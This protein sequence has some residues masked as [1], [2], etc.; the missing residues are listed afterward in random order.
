M[1]VV[2]TSRSEKKAL[3]TVRRILDSFADRIGNDTWKTVITAEGLSA[4]R[5]LLRKSATKN[6]AVACHWIRSRSRSDLVW[7]VGNRECFNDNG[8]VPVHSTKINILHRE[9]ENGWTYLPLLK[10]MVAVA[11]LF[12][13]YGKASDHFQQ[14]LKS[15]SLER[16]PFRHEWMSCK[17]L[18]AIVKQAGSGAHESNDCKWLQILQNGEMDIC[19][20]AR[21]VA[22]EQ[23]GKINF[24]KLPPLAQS[25]CWLILCHHKLPDLADKE[26]C[27]SFK[28]VS[29]KEFN[30]MLNSI[31]A[32]WGYENNQALNKDGCF[33]FSEGLVGPKQ[34]QW[35]KAVKKW[36]HRLLENREAFLCLFN[37][38]TDKNAFR[39]LLNY[40]R[41][42]LVLGDHYVSSMDAEN[43]GRWCNS[44]KLWAN[45][46]ISGMRQLL[47]E[48]LVRVC[49]QAVK[50]AHQLPRLT[51]QMESVTDNKT[52]KKKSSEKFKWQDTVVEEIKAFRKD[53]EERYAYFTINMASTGCGKTFANAKIMQALSKDGRSLR[54]ILALGLRSLTLQTGDE[55]RERIRLDDTE[56]AVLI[57]STAVRELHRQ[58]N[59][60]KEYEPAIDGNLEEL[61]EE[62][63][64]YVDT[65]D[66]EQ[67]KFLD[68][69]FKAVA[70]GKRGISSKQAAKNHALLYKPVLVATIDHMMGATE[71]VRGG[72]FLLPSLRLMSSD[73][74]IDEIDDFGKKDLIAISRLVHLAG[75]YGRNVT[76][77]SATIPPDLAEGLY[78]AYT[79]GLACHNRFFS[80]KKRPALIHCD[81]FK[82]QVEDINIKDRRFA[83]VHEYFVK[84]RVKKL[85]QQPIQRKAYI[86]NCTA[87]VIDEAE[88]CIEHNTVEIRYFEQ[89]KEAAETLHRQN[90]VCDKRTGKK[91]SFGVVRTANIKPCV[92]LCRYLL[93]CSWSKD[94]TVRV[95]AYH[96]RQILLLR[97]EQEKYLDKLLKRHQEKSN[98]ADFED[99]VV[100]K[101]IDSCDS[102]NILF[103]LVDTPVEEVGRDHDWDW[104]VVEPSSYRSIIQLAG[105]IRRHRRND[106][107]IKAYNMAIMQF[108]LRG[109]EKQKITFCRP[110]Y[111]S[112]LHLL[113]THDI[114]S[115]LN[116]T[117][118]AER[119]DAIPRIIK[120]E[121]LNPEERLIDLEHQVMLDFNSH[122]DGPK[123][124]NGWLE[125]YWWLTALPQR[126]NPFRESAGTDVKLW[127]IYKDE[128]L[129]F[130]E[131]NNGK[132]I[133][134]NEI[135]NISIWEG[136]NEI[137]EE[138]LWLYRDYKNALQKRIIADGRKDKTIILEEMSRQY[139][140]IVM[141]YN[142]N[143][144]QWYYSDHFG[145]F[146][147]YKE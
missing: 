59:Q 30:E 114:T 139:G 39:Q 17:L 24:N 144:S 81:E 55:Y 46:D 22:S 4:I 99:S 78:R 9:W 83:D 71:T 113:R 8:I 87:E 116:E 50:I 131:Y 125:E 52:L 2:F 112:G 21:M 49:E 35:H 140:E 94:I 89:I 29:K 13:D 32:D 56:L 142:T 129:D 62:E 147:E 101:H 120:A 73:L 3:Y 97:H 91:V 130:C 31:H 109:M 134:R 7:V 20:I 15:R 146:R 118:L 44:L 145:L 11:A 48:H 138:R 58:D 135:L 37:D 115:L 103:I 19:S 122:E 80:E 51:E 10:A 18:E 88:T 69:F 98:I 26:K 121:A 92:S 86:Q 67:V 110:G 111:E 27:R 102:E 123:Q 133:R 54:Y 43:T 33:T 42:C 16:D 53:K 119:V 23:D 41:I 47:E 100:R 143:N 25:V 132:Y 82:A 5:T 128:R 137:M 85:R 106:K 90:Y 1:M 12:H 136:M 107:G 6:M 117:E 40:A 75:M 45:T 28:D 61:V 72:R 57:G 70:P 66:D 65:E 36:T 124:L 68:I 74:V 93:S 76:I 104:A 63:I 141:P 105:R 64:E 38:K 108:N 34:V 77:S 84:K 127:A 60:D 95:M 79:A 126:F 96:S 14:K